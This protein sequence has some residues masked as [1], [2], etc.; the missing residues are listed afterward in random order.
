VLA[1]E[2]VGP[3]RLIRPVQV[4][5]DLI[6]FRQEERQVAIAH[7]GCVATRDEPP[8]RVLMNGLEHPKTGLS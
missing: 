8:T 5:L 1:L 7:R 2:A 4:R 6:G 3:C